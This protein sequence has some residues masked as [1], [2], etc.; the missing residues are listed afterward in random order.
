MLHST[1][2]NKER[3]KKELRVDAGSGILVVAVS[4]S[5]KSQV[6]SPMIFQRISLFFCSEWK[7]FLCSSSQP[8]VSEALPAPFLPFLVP[9]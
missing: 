6:F 9:L 3:F 1:V 2:K 8:L 4:F 5:P 7:T